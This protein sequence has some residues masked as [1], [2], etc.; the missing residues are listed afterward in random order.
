MKIMA[1]QHF[2]TC[3]THFTSS[4]TPRLPSDL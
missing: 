3:F 4:S 2:R 1:L